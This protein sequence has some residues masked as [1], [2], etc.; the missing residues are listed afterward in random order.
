MLLLTKLNHDRMSTGKRRIVFQQYGSK[1]F[2]TLP[3]KPV[4]PTAQENRNFLR[5]MWRA[6]NHST[7]RPSNKRDASHE[8]SRSH[9]TDI[10]KSLRKESRLP[11]FI[12]INL[13]TKDILNLSYR[14]GS[15]KNASSTRNSQTLLPKFTWS[16]EEKRNALVGVHGHFPSARSDLSETDCDSRTDSCDQRDKSVTSDVNFIVD[17][18]K[19]K[20]TVRESQFK[21]A[22][23]GYVKKIPDIIRKPG[24]KLASSAKEMSKYAKEKQDHAFLR[25]YS[26]AMAISNE[27]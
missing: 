24:V 8:L 11:P 2:E 23:S 22:D 9:D 18:R 1:S 3:R 13:D 20:K 5:I 17:K 14:R 12:K 26:P 7:P 21:K 10:G 25:N 4:K 15:G 6:Y 16:Q 19:T 27:G